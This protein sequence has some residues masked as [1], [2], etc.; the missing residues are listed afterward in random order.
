M[1][2]PQHPSWTPDPEPP[3]HGEPTG[4][5]YSSNQPEPPSYQQLQPGYGGVSAQ[6]YGSAD[7]PQGTTVLVL[8]ILGIF[9]P[10]LAPVAWYLGSRALREIRSSGARP[11]NQQHLVIGRLLGLVMTVLMIL[12]AV[13]GVVLFSLVVATGVQG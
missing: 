12:G 1:T 6:P 2:D 11:G 3:R 7:H 13:L 8:G 5:G 4:Y 9:F 10:I